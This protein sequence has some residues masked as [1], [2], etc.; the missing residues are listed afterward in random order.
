MVAV[1]VSLPGPVL[2]ASDFESIWLLYGVVAAVVLLGVWAW[3]HPAGPL[4]LVL[5]LITHSAYWMR[6]FGTANVPRRGPVL[7]LCT[8]VSY[9]DWLLIWVATPRRS[10]VLVLAGWAGRHGLRR[11]LRWTGAIVV[12]ANS[13]ARDVVMA[14]RDARAALGRGEAIILFVENQVTSTGLRVIFN[15]TLTRVVRGTD[16]VIVPACIDQAYSS[17]FMHNLG[18]FHWKLPP[19]WPYPID[20]VFGTPLPARTPVADVRQAVQQ[21]WADHAIAHANEIRPAHLQFIRMAAKHPFNPCLIDSSV[22]GGRKLTYGRSLAATVMLGKLLRPTLGETQNIGIWLPPS[23]GGALANIALAI[24]GKTSVNLNYS[25]SAQVVQASIRQAGIRHVLTSRRFTERMKFDGGPGVEV[26]Y[27]EDLLPKVSKVRALM[28]LLGAILLPGWLLQ[29]LLIHGK[30]HG[31]F[32]V[33]TLVF[34]SGSTGEP[35]GVVLTHANI[36]SNAN[37]IVQAVS[38]APRDRILGV[39]PFFHSFGYTVTLWTPMAAGA[40][41][42]YHP[43]P[44][45]AKEIGELCRTHGCTIYLSTATFLRFC[46]KRCGPDDFKSLHLIVCGAEKLPVA[47]SDDFEKRFGVRALEGYGCTEVSPA[48]VICHP[49]VVIDGFRQTFQRAG[50][51]GQPLPGIV[52]RIVHPETEKPLPFGEEGLLEILG[53][54][55][56]RGYLDR[57]DLTAKVVRNGWYATGDVGRM[58]ADGFVWLTGR[59][60]RFAKCGGEMVPLERIEE[61]LHDILSTSE[62]VC[63]VTCVPDESRGE[64]LLVLYVQSQLEQYNLEVRGWCQQ[65]VL[66][67]LPKLWVPAE[68]DFIA[69][70]EIPVL[71]SGKMDLKRLKDLALEL[72]GK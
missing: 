12:D 66:R 5:R 4:R 58:D 21:L 59:L 49:D 2:A 3:V 30:G 41:G 25:S 44:R 55:V 22:P 29:R 1:A 20:V 17:L 70:P 35:K 10:R 47:L 11:L 6:R 13:K 72:T 48:A 33:A 23:V 45:Q 67:G 54:N 39:L 63:G 37:A 14:M 38:A 60:S 64:R 36:A 18:R 56:M 16:A 24:L 34:S 71:G 42:V 15:R 7:V 68:R 27:L 9:L 46:L 31:P 32:D 19:S 69:V 65:L 28:V 51:I 57:P 43:D 53:P 52:G 26:I 61:V 40:T 50:S 62:R 8:P